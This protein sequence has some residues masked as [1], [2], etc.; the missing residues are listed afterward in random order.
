MVE[1]SVTVFSVEVFA[2]PDTSES[3]P[4]AM[5]PFPYLSAYYL[6]VN[7][8]L[9]GFGTSGLLELDGNCKVLSF[10]N[11]ATKLETSVNAVVAFVPIY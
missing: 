11:S 7:F 4:L 8:S 1:E 5:V 2:P 6:A 9:P 3:P 10:S